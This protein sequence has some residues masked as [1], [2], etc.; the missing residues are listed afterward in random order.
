MVTNVGFFYPTQ[1]EN[2]DA[3]YLKR[4]KYHMEITVLMFILVI[5]AVAQS[6]FCK[7]FGDNY[8][9][10]Q[11]YSAIVFTTLFGLS[12]GVFTW[13]VGGFPT[14]ISPYTWVFGLITACALF[15]YN[16]AL[17][18]ASQLG[19]Y[20][21][22]MLCLLFGG[23]MIPALSG[24]IF[25]NEKLSPIQLGAIVLMLISFVVINA[26]GITLKDVPKKYYV[27]CASLFMANG[28][29]GSFM[30]AQQVLMDATEREQ[31]IAVT[32]ISCGIMAFVYHLL[33]R[34]KNVIS[35]YEMDKKTSLYALI[36][37][38]SATITINLVMYILSK[39]PSAVVFTISNGSVLSLSVLCSFLFLKEQL[40]KNQIIGIAMSVIGIILFCL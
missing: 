8:K 22:T 15:L 38:V 37:C 28:L 34:K 32:Y 31:M 24:L 3:E 1:L 20:S 21:L 11:E 29:H 13:L 25:F 4:R 39:I 35:D 10:R 26:K 14:E 12:V 40:S 36:S 7:L 16:I 5:C 9:G 27:W 2:G 33:V 18:H 6:F 17:V 30:N 19:P 23:I